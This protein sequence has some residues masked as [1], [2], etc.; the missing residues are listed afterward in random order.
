MQNLINFERPRPKVKTK[1]P[2]Q[3]SV[4]PTPQPP[5]EH[6]SIPDRTR[7][8]SSLT[9]S[10]VRDIIPLKDAIDYDKLTPT[11]QMRWDA[12]MYGSIELKTIKGHQYYYLR[13][14]EQTTGR[15]RSTYLAKTW[16]DAIEKLR[17]LTGNKI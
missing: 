12:G 15:K 9:I 3:L 14:Q 13:W 8:K 6:R 11:Q 16:N 5:A 7:A 1:P 10:K 2:T 4:L 17:K